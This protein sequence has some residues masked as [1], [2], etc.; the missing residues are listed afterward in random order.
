MYGKHE[1]RRAKSHGSPLDR[2]KVSETERTEAV[3]SHPDE[4]MRRHG[5][6]GSLECHAIGLILS[7]RDTWGEIYT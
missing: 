5:L 7:R 6:V 4:M 2:A 1:F 3:G